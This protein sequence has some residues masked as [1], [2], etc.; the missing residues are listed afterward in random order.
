MDRTSVANLAGAGGL[1][2]YARLIVAE[3]RSISIEVG[4]ADMALIQALREKGLCGKLS[5]TT[6]EDGKRGLYA[7]GYS[8][9]M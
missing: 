8:K 1:D 5:D 2:D 7:K 9:K 6:S 4:S 3:K